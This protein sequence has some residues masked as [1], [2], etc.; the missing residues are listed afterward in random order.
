MAS[1]VLPDGGAMAA[2]DVA[3]E[4]HALL[5]SMVITAALGVIGVIW[6]VVSES[7]MILLDGVYAV[8]GL[9]VTWLL[10]MASGLAQAEP[11]HRYPYGRE[12]LTP[13]VIGVQGFVLLATL[14]YA[15]VDAVPDDPRRWKQRRRRLGNRVQRADDRRVAGDVV[16][17]AVEGD[18]DQLGCAR[19]G[20]DGVED[21]RTSRSWG[22]SSASR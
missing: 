1:F 8:L 20:V 4:R 22:W 6:G 3:V 11:S 10:L 19:L 7:Q 12:S 14:G 13:L 17:A 15:A 5:R 9:L 16:V 21:R 2:A 18:L